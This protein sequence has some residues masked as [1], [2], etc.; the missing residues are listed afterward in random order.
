M[1]FRTQLLGVPLGRDEKND[2][3]IY[4]YLYVTVEEI[5]RTV[6]NIIHSRLTLLA[7]VGRQLAVRLGEKSLTTPCWVKVGR[8]MS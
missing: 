7:A 5:V 6:D 8:H 4:I 2:I 3:Y 1:E